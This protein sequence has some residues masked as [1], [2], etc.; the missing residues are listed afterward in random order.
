MPEPVVWQLSGGPDDRSYVDVFYRH[1]IG[2]IGPGDPGPWKSQGMVDQDTAVRRFAEEFEI[3]DVVVLREGTNRVH[4]IGVVA[5]P[6][7]YWRQFDDVNGWDLQHGRRIRWHPLPS[8]HRFATSVFGANPSRVSRVHNDEVLEHVGQWLHS[9]LTHWQE[10]PLPP[11][12]AGELPL[13]D[14]DQDLEDLVAL[15]QDMSQLYWNPDR[16]GDEPSEFET[17]AHYVVPLLRTLG[18]PPEHIAVEWRRVDVAVFSSLPRAPDNCRF[19]IEAKRLGSGL[20]YARDQAAGYSQTLGIPR[21]VIVTDGF[22]YRM[23][24]YENDFAPVAYAN[25]AR[26]KESARDF[27]A[28]LRRN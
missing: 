14:L 28:R 23:F 18:W 16:L 25:L 4:A 21:D 27:F 7:E 9:G 6:Y 20:A 2:L 3:G 12:P 8:T 11:L 19:L 10:A 24:S 26:L 5:G 15:V 22:R 13:E 17:I 1:S